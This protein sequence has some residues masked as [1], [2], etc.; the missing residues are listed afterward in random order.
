MRAGLHAVFVILSVLGSASA[1]TR[2]G[3]R[4]AKP[5][6][7]TLL[8]PALYSSPAVEGKLVDATSGQAI[9]GAVILAI[10]READS[11]TEHWRGIFYLAET[12]TDEHGQFVIHRW[13]PRP[14]SADSYIDK[15]DPE[16]WVI[17]SGYLAGYFD[18]AGES[19]PMIPKSTEAP[20]FL[21]LPPAKMPDWERG[22]YARGATEPSIWNARELRL[23]KATSADEAA[24]SLA[25]ANPL[26]PHLPQNSFPLPL[27]WAEWHRARNSLP[28]DT[29]GTVPFPPHSML[30]YD[31][32]VIR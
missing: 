29:Q 10:W 24:R 6:I 32:T 12:A 28:P 31:V 1:M 15:R 17:K 14:S 19:V 22:K 8:A 5:G 18:N 20:R 26:D 30:D 7:P 4:N 11:R 21:K 23:R 25:A 13:G 27:F 2:C 9:D 3:D 16:I